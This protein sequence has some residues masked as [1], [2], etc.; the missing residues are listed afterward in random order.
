MAGG[1]D[2]ATAS[3]EHARGSEVAARLVVHEHELGVRL[4]VLVQLEVAEESGGVAL[5]V[6]LKV[7]IVREVEVIVLLHDI[8]GR[9]RRA[10]ERGVA[11][12]A[13]A[14]QVSCC[15]DGRRRV[16]RAGAAEH[17]GATSRQSA[18]GVI[19]MTRSNLV[20]APIAEV[21]CE[22][23]GAIGEAVAEDERQVL[24]RAVPVGAGDGFETCRLEDRSEPVLMV[25]VV[26]DSNIGIDAEAIEV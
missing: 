11:D 5:I 14:F 16:A 1:S 22:V 25:V 21:A 15:D 23:P 6:A 3:G 18:S 24:L 2:S 9:P 26:I 17:G 8:P 10:P 4:G 20:R 13:L 12:L 7:E 19:A